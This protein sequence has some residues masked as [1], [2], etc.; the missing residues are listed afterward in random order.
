MRRVRR[1]SIYSEL[2]MCGRGVRNILLLPLVARYLETIDACIWR[3]FV[4]I[5]KNTT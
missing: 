4:E 5:D 2:L 1:V 3:K